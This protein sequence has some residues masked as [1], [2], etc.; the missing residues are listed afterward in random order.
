MHHNTT[1]ATWN[2][3]QN[4]SDWKYPYGWISF[5][6][7][8]NCFFYTF[9]ITFNFHAFSIVF[10][11]F[12][13]T[14]GIQFYAVPTKEGISYRNCVESTYLWS[15]D[16]P[17]LVLCPCRTRFMHNTYPIHVWHRFGIFNSLWMQNVHVHFIVSTKCM[18]TQ[19]I[20]SYISYFTLFHMKPFSCSLLWLKFRKS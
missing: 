16:T 7:Y 3:W 10:Y 13:F 18:V 12:L 15:M 19:W 1:T 6:S 17:N 4:L 11:Y 5:T 8:V 2:T 14:L 20:T 9:G